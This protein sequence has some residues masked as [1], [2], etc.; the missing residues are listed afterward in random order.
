MRILHLDTGRE[1][2]GG[3]HQALLLHESLAQRDCEQTLLAGP[4]IRSTH[5]FEAITLSSIRRH[6]A[7]CDLIHAHDARAHTLALIHGRGKPVVVARRV[8]FPIGR[9]PAS[10]WKYR[11][12][13]HFIAI[14]R[15]VADTL[16][17]GGVPPERV[18][19]VYDAAPDEEIFRPYT[20]SG[21]SERRAGR[22]DF[23]VV[24]P[25]SDDPLKGRD[26][27]VAACLRSGAELI[28]SDNLARDVPWADLLLYVSKSE[29]LGSAILIAMLAGL[30]VVASNVGGIP[31]AVENGVTG[32][33]A[34]ND[35]ASIAEAISR[36]RTD[37]GMRERMSKAAFEKVKVKFNRNRMAEQTAR[38]YARVLGL[39]A[40]SQ[41]EGSA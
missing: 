16:A 30:P 15:H 20:P 39:P 3:Q 5:G 14:S 32:V 21:A 36:V 18:S 33:L 29:G 6:S 24:T 22:N 10:R 31:E 17:S 13:A 35:V 27:A 11:K 12:A 2:R 38:V 8:A 34:E 9:G 7:K 41:D 25:S 1:M 26:L 37:R 19:V 23:I 4:A 40:A 28:V